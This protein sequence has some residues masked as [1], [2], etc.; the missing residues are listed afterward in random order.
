VADLRNSLSMLLLDLGK[1]TVC[2]MGIDL[3]VSFGSSLLWSKLLSPCVPGPV[4]YLYSTGT[5][6]DQEDDGGADGEV[7]GDGRW[8]PVILDGAHLSL[9]VEGLGCTLDT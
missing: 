2:G 5:Q 7:G 1:C 4:Y 3:A 6:H 9:H 8:L